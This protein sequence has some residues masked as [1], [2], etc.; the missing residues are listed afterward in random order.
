MFTPNNDMDHRPS[1]ETSAGCESSVRK[2]PSIETEAQGGGSGASDC[3][4]TV[5]VTSETL[6]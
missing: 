5:I 3:S 4:A 2:I 1:L 6:L